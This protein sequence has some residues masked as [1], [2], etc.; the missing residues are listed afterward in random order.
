M[1]KVEL[2]LKHE[3]DSMYNIK[4]SICDVY[5]YNLDDYYNGCVHNH[6]IYCQEIPEKFRMQ[7][8][9]DKNYPNKHFDYK[10]LSSIYLHGFSFIIDY[11]VNKV[12][13]LIEINDNIFYEEVE[14][15]YNFEKSIHY[16]LYKFRDIEK[17]IYENIMFL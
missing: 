17:E 12:F 5:T 7:H 14:I 13:K 15:D 6:L 1:S 9:M 4:C 16:N 8:P 2:M 10:K 3:Y 11:V